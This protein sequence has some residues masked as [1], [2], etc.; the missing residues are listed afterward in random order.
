L[1]IVFAVL[2][3]VTFAFVFNTVQSNTIAES[4]KTQYNVSPVI[5][6]I[7]LAILTAVI[8][9]GG[10]RSIAT[11]SSVIVPILAILYIFTV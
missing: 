7:I 3:T 1:G 10:V 8:I 9:F 2:I 5:T 6:G 4:L 11:M